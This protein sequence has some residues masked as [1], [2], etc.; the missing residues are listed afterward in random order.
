M[1]CFWRAATGSAFPT[2]R[3]SGHLDKWRKYLT[4]WKY[5]DFLKNWAGVSSFR[6]LR[7]PWKL[8]DWVSWGIEC[9][10]GSIEHLILLTDILLPLWPHGSDG[11]GR[12]SIGSWW[13]KKQ[14]RP[15]SISVVVK[16]Q[17]FSAFWTGCTLALQFSSA[18]CC[19]V[20]IVTDSQTPF[21]SLSSL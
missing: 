17:L 3:S 21:Y 14:K 5:K 2:R 19:L 11:N 10:V 6:G 8:A 12:C 18:P 20:G 1:S 15:S 7:A 16:T 4:Y 9:L 13:T